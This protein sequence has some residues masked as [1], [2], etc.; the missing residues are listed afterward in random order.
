MVT[1]DPRMTHQE[2]IAH[3]LSADALLLMQSTPH[4]NMQIPAKFY[5]YLRAGRPILTM[6]PLDSATAQI[7]RECGAGWQVDAKDPAA[8]RAVLMEMIELHRAGRLKSDHPSAARFERRQL[9]VR[10]AEIMRQCCHSVPL[11][12]QESPAVV[13]SE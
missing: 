13:S 1:L 7:A 6:A 3:V 5:E 10:L 4:T 9:T 2:C 12:A 8:L 11:A